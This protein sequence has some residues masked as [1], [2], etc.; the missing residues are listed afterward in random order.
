MKD[1][2]KQNQKV[3]KIMKKVNNEIHLKSIV[4][5]RMVYRKFCTPV[6]GN[7]FTHIPL[8]KGI[9]NKS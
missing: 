5:Y 7:T 3:S 9:S 6:E 2:R 4:A 1:K 8:Q